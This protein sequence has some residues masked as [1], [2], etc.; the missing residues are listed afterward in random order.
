[1]G[2]YGRANN[3][4]KFDFAGGGLVTRYSEHHLELMMQK[5]SLLV[6]DMDNVELCVPNAVRRPFG[7]SRAGANV[8]GTGLYRANTLTPPSFVA[9]PMPLGVT[10]TTYAWAGNFKTIASP[11]ILSSASVYI[12][13]Y[14]NAGGNGADSIIVCRA[15][16]KADSAGVPGS[17][18]AT[19]D[20]FN[21][22]SQYN[23]VAPG[24]NQFDLGKVSFNFPTPPTLAAS[25]EY[26]LCIEFVGNKRNND[27]VYIYTAGTV[28]G[29]TA[30]TTKTGYT[31]DNY[32][33]Y[34]SPTA[35]P[36]PGFSGYYLCFE[37]R[38]STPQ[39]FGLWDL[40][41]S[42]GS[43]GV[44]RFYGAACGGDLYGANPNTVAGSNWTGSWGDPICTG[45][46][47]VVDKYYDMVVFKNLAFFC[48]HA[49]N[50]SRAWDGVRGLDRTPAEASD[51]TSTMI[52]GYRPLAPTTKEIDSHPITTTDVSWDL[53]LGATMKFLL[54]TR[55]ESGGY[56]ARY[57]IRFIGDQ[58][59]LIEI[60]TSAGTPIEIQVDSTSSEFYFDITT[61][62]TTL[63]A[64]TPGG[65]I[66]YKVP[67]FVDGTGGLAKADNSATTNPFP[68]DL[69]VL[70]VFPMT[71]A[72]MTAQA[73]LETTNGFSTAYYTSQV[74]TPKAK[75][76]AVYANS[77]M[78]AG[79]PE[80]PSRVWI[81]E[82]FAPQV[83]GT[84]GKT[85]GSYLDIAPDDGETITGLKVSAKCLQVSKQSRFYRVVY[86]GDFNDPWRVDDVDGG[87]GTYSHWSM[88][89]VPEG[90]LFMSQRG[91]AINYGSRCDMLPAT[92]NILNLFDYGD[93]QSFDKDQISLIHSCNDRTRNQIYFTMG[94]HNSD[95]RDR[96]L[97]YN[98]EQAKWAICSSVVASVMCEMGD[99][100][101]LSD[102]WI[103][104]YDGGVLRKDVTTYAFMGKIQPFMLE[105]PFMHLTSPENA[106]VGAFIGMD[107]KFGYGIL[108]VD[109]FVDD[110][111]TVFQTIEFNLQEATTNGGVF[112]QPLACIFRNIKLKFRESNSIGELQVNAIWIDYTDEGQRL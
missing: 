23:N 38:I 64:T 111:D 48:D 77:L 33:T 21:I 112:K 15:V 76:M 82:Q 55:L 94:S 51:A 41:Y 16:I 97:V 92:K 87:L 86:T 37:L 11:G 107:A 36:S 12:S 106:K 66:F 31:L 110:S 63:W 58:K 3:R 26:W 69:G 10:S 96:I 100:Q 70:R 104:T 84:Y 18:V 44:T 53:S 61:L 62:A 109:V 105:T 81:S 102:V 28:S 59:S 56:R 40:R 93:P 8:K 17:V 78:T 65:G 91:P 42:N 72:T 30:G 43:G 13:F 25:T 34:W 85:K 27:P 45:L 52:H 89:V 95:Q 29:G 54:V 80:N 90:L 103:G 39:M 20:S 19:S 46:S 108:Y 98:Y 1:M 88:Q 67:G 22:V 79:D 68:N 83:F 73:D 2:R 24:P 99:A 71:N 14:G 7:Y 35:I 5:G 47:S 49:T 75:Y 6:H 57:F 50:A 74:D 101:G 32:S 60:G 4:K 9:M